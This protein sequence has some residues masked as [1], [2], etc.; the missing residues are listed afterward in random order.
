M[1]PMVDYKN[2]FDNIDFD[3]DDNFDEVHSLYHAI[4][5]SDST[6]G[7]NI[8]HRDGRLI[9]RYPEECEIELSIPEEEKD[10]F[11]SYLDSLYE[12]TVD[13]EYALRQAMSH[14]D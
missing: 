10:Q 12:L 13:G 11:I 6:C 5:D 14:N 9:V 2:W 4:K 1:T 8:D 7:V 3:L